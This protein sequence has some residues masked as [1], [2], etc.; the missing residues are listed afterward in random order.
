MKTNRS[1]EAKIYVPPLSFDR[2]ST[3]SKEFL[4]YTTRKDAHHDLR[5]T[6]AYKEWLSAKRYVFFLVGF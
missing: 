4:T 6:E 2:N 5:N 1:D 3:F